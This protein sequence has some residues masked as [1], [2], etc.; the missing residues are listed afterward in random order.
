VRAYRD[1]GRDD[2]RTLTLRSTMT[3]VVVELLPDAG[4]MIGVSA[5]LGV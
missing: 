2:V 5:A 1:E 3:L 4:A